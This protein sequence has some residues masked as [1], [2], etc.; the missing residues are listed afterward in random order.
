MMIGMMVM[1]M[2]YYDDFHFLIVVY[3][4]L[5]HIYHHLSLYFKK[6]L[7]FT[8]YTL[9]KHTHTL[10]RFLSVCVSLF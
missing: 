1:R 10:T 6:N 5:L 7:N 8:F 2:K 4:V 3:L 9:L